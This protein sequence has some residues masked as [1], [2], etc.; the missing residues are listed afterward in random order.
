M[1]MALTVNRS[2]LGRNDLL[3][4][5][6]RQRIERMNAPRAHRRVMTEE[7][8]MAGTGEGHSI[9][10][11]CERRE[12]VEACASGGYMDRRRSIDTGGGRAGGRV[13]DPVKQQENSRL[14]KP[15]R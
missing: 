14:G 10:R 4:P 13:K 9:K 3:D 2:A 11:Q 5:A 6:N 12:C 7:N 1:I 15:V 8:R